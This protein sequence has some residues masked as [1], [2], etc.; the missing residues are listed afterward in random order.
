MLSLGAESN[1][2]TRERGFL[3]QRKAQRPIPRGSFGDFLPGRIS[4]VYFLQGFPWLSGRPTSLRAY[5]AFFRGGAGFDP[6]LGLDS[7]AAKEQGAAVIDPD[8]LDGAN[9]SGGDVSTW[10]VEHRDQVPRGPST[11]LDWRILQ[12]G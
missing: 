12:C 6:D 3:R 9:A 8:S 4:Q 2:R 10:E 5:R 7:G 1:H 11:H